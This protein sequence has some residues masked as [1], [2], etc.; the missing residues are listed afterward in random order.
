MSEQH[1]AI[2]HS[3]TY[4]WLRQHRPVKKLGS[5]IRL[6]LVTGCP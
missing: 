4:Q 2:D 6:Y 3:V 1:P 5:S